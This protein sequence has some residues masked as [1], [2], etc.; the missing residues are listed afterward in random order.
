[1]YKKYS[2]ERSVKLIYLMFTYLNKNSVNY[3][4]DKERYE[5][6]FN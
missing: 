5:Q 2:Q 6:I 4:K 1:M 3:E